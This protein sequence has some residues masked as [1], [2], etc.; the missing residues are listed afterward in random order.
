MI[1]EVEI[2]L[3]VWINEKQLAGGTVN[4]PIIRGKARMLHNGLL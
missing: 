3:R 4:E 1:E 2:L